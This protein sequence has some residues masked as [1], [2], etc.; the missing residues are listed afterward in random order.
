MEQILKDHKTLL[1]TQPNPKHKVSQVEFEGLVDETF[2]GREF[3]DN[4]ANVMTQG[5][6]IC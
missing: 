1:T 6:G 4:T 2:L 3:R 5:S